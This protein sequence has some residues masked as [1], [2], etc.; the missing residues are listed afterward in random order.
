MNDPDDFVNLLPKEG[1][2]LGDLDFVY[3]VKEGETN[4][5]LRYSLRSLKNV[6]HRRVIIVG[7]MPSWVKNV[8]NIPIPQRHANK[9]VNT[10]T[11]WLR[12]TGVKDISRCFVLM[13]DDMFFLQKVTDLPFG[14]LGTHREF[15]A[16][17]SRDHPNSYY[18]KVIHNTA[19]RM[20][21]LGIE[22]PMCYEL[23]NP[24]II[25]KQAIRLAL[26]GTSYKFAPINI[27]TV[28]LN[29]MEVGGEL[30]PDVK[31]YGTKEASKN[32]KQ[33]IEDMP[34]VSTADGVWNMEVGHYIRSKF[35][36]KGDYEH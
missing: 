16:R 18:T 3:T 2:N 15:V 1:L 31:F 36:T 25:S 35:P 28:A 5:E 30:M 21:E 10:N 29:L 11:N 24:T 34:I 22:L 9:I 19:R 14:H 26:A 13:N 7:Y 23:H 4:E 20:I 8:I 12:A 33:K 27:R 17:Y 6:P 32:P